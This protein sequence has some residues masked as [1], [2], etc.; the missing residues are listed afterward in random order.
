MG[1]KRRNTEQESWSVAHAR[2][3]RRLHMLDPN[4]RCKGDEFEDDVASLYGTDD[5]DDDNDDPRGADDD[6]DS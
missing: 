4:D 2:N 1:K 6:D 5:D 3:Y